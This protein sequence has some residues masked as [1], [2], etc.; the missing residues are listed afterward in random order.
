M[1]AQRQALDYGVKYSAVPFILLMKEW[2]AGHYSA[3]SSACY[4]DD[5]TEDTLTERFY[6]EEHRIY[7]EAI[8]LIMRARWN[9]GKKVV[10]LLG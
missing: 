9:F 8:K 1:N 4:H 3:G 5:D 2:T 10:R 6:K 7:P